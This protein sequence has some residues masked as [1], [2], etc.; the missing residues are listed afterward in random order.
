MAERRKESGWDRGARHRHRKMM[1]K[2]VYR[3]REFNISDEITK[4]LLGKKGSEF[5]ESFHACAFAFALAA[6]LCGSKKELYC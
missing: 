2:R 3:Q 4:S 5:Y 6:A 1:I